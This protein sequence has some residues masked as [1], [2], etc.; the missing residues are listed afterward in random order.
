MPFFRSQPGGFLPKRR[1]KGP[2]F[3]QYVF[4]R[5][6]NDRLAVDDEQLTKFY[7]VTLFRAIDMTRRAASQ[8]ARPRQKWICVRPSSNHSKPTGSPRPM[9]FVHTSPTPSR[10]KMGLHGGACFPPPSALSEN[11]FRK[12]QD[13]SSGA[14]LN[15]VRIRSYWPE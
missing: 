11:E 4:A 14:A 1:K 7:E 13:L 3:C 9:M 6:V 10:D 12:S 2:F 5:A 8:R 15:S